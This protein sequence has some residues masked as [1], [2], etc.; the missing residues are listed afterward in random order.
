MLIGGKQNRVVNISLLIGPNSENLIPVSCVEQGRWSYS[1]PCLS[2]ADISDTILRKQI[3]FE[4]SKSL[5]EHMNV[6]VDQRNVW[7]HVGKVL[8]DSRS[9]S[10]SAPQ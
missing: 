8:R 9:Q 3:C 1:S 6:A 7:G 2:S 4:S 10:L 5:G